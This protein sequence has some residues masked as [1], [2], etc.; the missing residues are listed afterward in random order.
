MNRSKG[1][2]VSDVEATIEAL[3]SEERVFEPPAGFASRAVVS[4]PAVY[5]RATADPE[6]FWAE[7]A[8]SLDWIRKWDTVL[9]WEPPWAKWF[10]GGKLNV[11]A[12]CLDRHVASGG[13]DRGPVTTAL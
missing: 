1:A 7:Q 3:L 8:E 13:G 9:E 10:L 5:E 4:D 12:N 6:G 11:A 2:Q